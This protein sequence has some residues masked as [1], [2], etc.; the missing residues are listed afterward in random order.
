MTLRDDLRAAI[1]EDLVRAR[2]L[3]ASGAPG[4]RDAR[5]RMPRLMADLLRLEQGLPIR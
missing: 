1:V 4:C 5:A 2:A 3:A